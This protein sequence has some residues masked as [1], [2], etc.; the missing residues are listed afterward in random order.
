MLSIIFSFSLSCN[1]VDIAELSEISKW[2]FIKSLSFSDFKLVG[3][4]NRFDL[5]LNEL[6]ARTA[7]NELN[8]SNFNSFLTFDFQAVFTKNLKKFTHLKKLTLNHLN[9]CFSSKFCESLVQLAPTLTTLKLKIE[10]I[11]CKVFSDHLSGFKKFN[12]LIILEIICKNK[13]SD[14]KFIKNS[15]KK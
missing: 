6:S 13:E 11:D 12:S 9:F 14:V 3:G 7:L 5:F 1:N 10:N 2:S 4:V 15:L 8:L